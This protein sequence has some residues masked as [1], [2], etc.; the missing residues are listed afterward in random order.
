M[1]ARLW[2]LLVSV[3]CTSAG[4]EPLGVSRAALPTG[5]HEETVASVPSPTALAF[6]PDGTLLVTER[7]GKV[8]VIATLMNN[9]LPSMPDASTL[10][11]QGF[12]APEV[13]Q[14][15]GFVGPPG[16]PANVRAYWEGVLTK[17]YKSSEWQGFLK[18]NLYEDGFLIGPGLNKFVD[19]Y[20]NT[21]RGILQE[22]GIKVVR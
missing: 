6:L 18:E 13:P 9:R 22:A 16:M 21:M 8:R 7:T 11:E 2:P 12:K 1:H 10:K 5:F 4:P 3:A 17:M 19:D 20:G 14:S 15:R